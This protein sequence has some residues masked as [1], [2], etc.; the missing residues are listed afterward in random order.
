MRRCRRNSRVNELCGVSCSVVLRC[1]GASVGSVYVMS[2]L[3]SLFSSSALRMWILLLSLALSLYLWFI[4]AYV[5]I[6][7]ISMQRYDMSIR[8]THRI[9]QRRRRCRRRRHVPFQKPLTQQNPIPFGLKF[10]PRPLQTRR[11]RTE[12]SPANVD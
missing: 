2:C 9:R 8:D 11:P 10:I 7:H 4:C 12:S 5:Y 3:F 1:F 6:V